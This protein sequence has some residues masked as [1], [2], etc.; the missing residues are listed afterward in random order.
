LKKK[1]PDFYAL[2]PEIVRAQ[3]LNVPVV[4]LE[5][6]V[7]THGLPYPEN[8]DLAVKMGQVI[9]AQGAVPAAIG[10]LKGKIHIGMDDEQL[11]E[12]ANQKNPRKVSSRDFAAVLM[13]NAAGGTTV[14]GTLIAAHQAGIKVFATGGIGGVH[15][16]APWDVSTDLIELSRRPLLVV[17]AGAKAILDLSATTEYLETIGV[18]VIGFQTDC[19]PAFYSRESDYQ[20]SQRVDTAQEVAAIARIH[21]EMGLSS[22]ILVVVPA[23]EK[24]ALPSREVEEVIE[25]ALVDADEVGVRGQAVTPY[26]LSR[27]S[28]LTGE[29]SLKANLGLLLNNAQVA[30]QIAVALD[31]KRALNAA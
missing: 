31:D 21:W 25:Q 3:A 6:T 16:N 30:A 11:R 23:P 8:I 12:L 7:M 19:F 27:L 29:A 26:L 13:T 1:L 10:L 18:P 9:R 17:C 15:R 22:S 14:A 28:E 5:T 4:A 20:V 2:S 24:V